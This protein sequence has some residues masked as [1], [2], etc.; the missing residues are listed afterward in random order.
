MRCEQGP[1]VEKEGVATMAGVD[2][3]RP[4]KRATEAIPHEFKAILED[5]LI[6]VLIM[7][8][9]TS[10]DEVA[11]RLLG[12]H[13]PPVLE[14]LLTASL[15]VMSGIYAIA[16]LM[17]M[18]KLIVGRLLTKRDAPRIWTADKPGRARPAE[19]ALTT[20]A[21]R[22]SVLV[23]DDDHLASTAVKQVLAL[24]PRI[25]TITTAESPDAAVAK[26]ESGPAQEAPDVVLLDV[27][28]AGC[29]KTGIDSL[30]DLHRAA[31]SSRLVV[32]SVCREPATIKAAIANDADGFIW[33]N[34][35]AVDFAEAV[36]GAAHSFVA[37][38]SVAREFFDAG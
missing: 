5:A 38:K 27:N 6:L 32:M 10:A 29:E 36:V 30:P 1:E 33:K 18:R 24:D 19:K 15:W 35:S 16:V 22:L 20:E 34:E 37:S 21:A 31:P 26:I 17:T 23:V 11:T 13:I 9:A 8:A 28:Y 4:L 7:V 3:V 2:A 12:E 25:G 14:G